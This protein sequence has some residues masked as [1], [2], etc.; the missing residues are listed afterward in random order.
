VD[1]R[2][3]ANGEEDL[4]DLQGFIDEHRTEIS[5]AIWNQCPNIPLDDDELRQWIANDE[6]L[7]RWAQG[8]GYDV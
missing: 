5:V 7:Y 8:E 6:G 3:L 1:K 2:L 4:K